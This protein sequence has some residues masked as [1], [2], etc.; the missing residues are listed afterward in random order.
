[1]MKHKILSLV[2]AGLFTSV[3]AY[4]GEA[5]ADKGNSAPK[6]I[7]DVAKPEKAAGPKAVA[8]SASKEGVEKQAV[9][10]S[11]FEATLNQMFPMSP[12]Q[13]RQFGKVV[14][15]QQRAKTEAPGV[16]GRPVTS[17]VRVSS[18]PG[19]IPP[20]I[21]LGRGFVSTM[22]FVDSSGAQ[23]PVTGFSVGNP[24]KF[25]VDPAQEGETNVL[26]LT[27]L[28]SYI[29]SNLAV[30]LKGR[31]TPVSFTVISDQRE[32]DYRLDVSMDER[33]PNAKPPVVTAD[34]NFSMD[35]NMRSAL[36]GVKPKD[37]LD[38]KVS[39]IEGQ[40]WQVGNNKVL[41][42]TKA[43]LMS[44][45]WSAHAVSADGTNLYVIPNIPVLIAFDNGS[46]VDVKI[47]GVKWHSK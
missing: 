3:N 16:V 21:R 7:K 39:G 30:M 22:V 1:M 45:A 10:K 23:W 12:K 36:D 41:L 47:E 35:A 37:A 31:Q 42:R 38:M 4:A 26:T 27:P 32:T 40:A 25:G 46:Q 29:H 2:L 14:D 5:A 18:A 28:G 33:G 34:V 9:P 15:E 44:P 6:E 8:R 20:V 17:T 13:V 19:A 11:D 43:T 24:D